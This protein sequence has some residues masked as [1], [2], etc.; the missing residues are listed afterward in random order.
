MIYS[1][2]AETTQN[3][4]QLRK[5][6]PGSMVEDTSPNAKP[7]IFNRSLSSPNPTTSKP[8]LPPANSFR[9]SKPADPDI[10]KTEPEHLKVPVENLE[11]EDSAEDILNTSRV[12]IENET[13]ANQSEGCTVS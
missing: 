9:T 13:A 12:A 5:M 4:F 6:S 7:P 1:K 8:N 2:Y 3:N 11:I 10:S